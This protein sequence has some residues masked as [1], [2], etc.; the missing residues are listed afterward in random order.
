MIDP[1]IKSIE[2]PCS[3]QQAFKVFVDEMDSWWPLGRF[4]VSAMGGATA[5]SIRIEAKQGG[6]I[7]EIGPDGEE[8]LW[9]TIRSCDPHGFVS[10][11][12]HIPQPGEQVGYR[13]LVEVRFISLGNERT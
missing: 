6:K 1:I 8:H 12:F 4:T 9:G 11:D 2:V 3:Q 5:R 13:S 10:M 7:V